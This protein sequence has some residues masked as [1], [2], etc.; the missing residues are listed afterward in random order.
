MTEPTRGQDWSRA[1][2]EAVVADYLA[3]LAD[4][5]TGTPV[6]KTQHRQMLKPLLQGRSDGSIERKHQNI[7][8]ILLEMG[9]PAIEGYKPLR[10]YQGLLAEVVAERLSADRSLHGALVEDLSREVVVPTVDQILLTLTEAPIPPPREREMRERKQTVPPPPRGVNYLELE[11]RNS[12]LGKAGEEL[13]VNYE[14]AWLISQGRARLADQVE[15]V[16]VTRGDGLGFD[17]LS[18][19]PE[20]REKFVEV[21]TTKY[22]RYTPF[23]ATRGEVEFSDRNAAG[24]HLARVFDF[25][26]QPRFFQVAGPIRQHF[27]IDPVQ[28]LARIA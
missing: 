20:G 22:G 26:A 3:M 5:L 2:V 19:D 8:A 7:S 23:F 27:D 15:H 10:N 18:F 14:R 11:A 28:F 24:F 1:E 4:E 16:A 13:V 9:Y 17:I 6:N 25:R 21:K 12:S